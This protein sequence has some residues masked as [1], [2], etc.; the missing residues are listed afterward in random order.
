MAGG[1]R[2][3]KG[4]AIPKG[5]KTQQ[6]QAM[7]AFR[8]LV[9]SDGPIRLGF[10]ASPMET[11]IRLQDKNGD[12]PC[13]AFTVV[14]AYKRSASKKGSKIICQIPSLQGMC[15]EDPDV[16]MTNYD[17]IFAIDTNTNTFLRKSI[18]VS[19]VLGG[20]VVGLSD[21]DS[22]GHDVDFLPVLYYEFWDQP[23]KPETFA[24]KL[25]TRELVNDP[26]AT[27]EDKV[28]IVVDSE[29]GSI[30]TINRGTPCLTTDLVLPKNYYLVYASADVSDFGVNRLISH[31][32][33]E[34]RNFFN[35]LKAEYTKEGLPDG[36]PFL[37]TWFPR[38]QGPPS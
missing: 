27:I 34:A 22:E 17:W 13:E 23:G 14:S 33:K 30:E 9:E 15:V 6:R 12:V 29:L 19:C 1:H 26:A 8:P 18:S 37:R 36:T 20:R 11:K 7:L 32:D 25:L 4:K 16:H 10:A 28:A 35:S 5:Q 38:I 2:K 21:H 24:W 31:C 3:R